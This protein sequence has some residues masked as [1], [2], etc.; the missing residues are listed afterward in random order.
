MGSKNASKCNIKRQSSV[1]LIL[2]L[3]IFCIPG[4]Q[5]DTEHTEV[6]LH[7]PTAL[8]SWSV[9]DLGNGVVFHTF[10][11]VWIRCDPFIHYTLVSSGVLE[12]S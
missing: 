11:L 4:P 1:G 10:P 7:W 5:T 9:V 3:S 2:I 8:S 6:T 12:W